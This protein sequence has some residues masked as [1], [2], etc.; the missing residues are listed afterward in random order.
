MQKEARRNAHDHC[1]NSSFFIINDH[2]SFTSY[3]KL[4]SSSDG[5]SVPFGDHEQPRQTQGMPLDF[6][7]FDAL[8]AAELTHHFT[9]DKENLTNHP[10]LVARRCYFMSFV[11][12]CSHLPHPVL[13]P[14]IVADPDTAY[15]TIAALHMQPLSCSTVMLKLADPNCYSICKP[16]F[17]SIDT[18]RFIMRGAIRNN[19][20]LIA[21]APLAD[22]IGDKIAPMGYETLKELSS[23]ENIDARVRKYANMISHPMGTCA[24]VGVIDV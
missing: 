12:Y 2:S 5:Y 18:D 6:T 9:A 4:K 24:L 21:T 19:L 1:I 17:F 3:F 20:R 16:Q 13:Y 22:A 15:I 10:A 8:T 14:S 23:D 7:L 11:V